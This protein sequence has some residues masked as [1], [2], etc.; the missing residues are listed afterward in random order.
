MFIKAFLI[1]ALAAVVHGFTS[2]GIRH[3]FTMS[4]Q[5][6]ASLPLAELYANPTARYNGELIDT[7]LKLVTPAPKPDGY[8]YGDVNA[9]ATPV[10]ILGAIA[11]LVL[12]AAVPRFL[13]IGDVAKRQQEKYEQAPTALK[14]LFTKKKAAALT[15]GA[16]RKAAPAPVKPTAKPVAKPVAKPAP[17]PAT[18]FGAKAPVPVK[19]VEAPAT[20]KK[21]FKFW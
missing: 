21:S 3:A 5:N 13:A 9:G 1:A 11:S 7:K 2:K 10:L 17:K 20:T 19:G 16:V 12:A 8:V 18:K 15:V 14:P 6:Y 4:I